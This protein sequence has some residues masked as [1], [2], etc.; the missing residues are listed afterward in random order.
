MN[1]DYNIKTMTLHELRSLVR[2]EE[3]RR[4]AAAL[5][6]AEEAARASGYNLKELLGQRQRPGRKTTATG[7]KAAKIFELMQAGHNADSACRALGYKNGGPAYNIVR[8]RG[9]NIVG[10]YLVKGDGL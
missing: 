6:A 8:N 5:D 2:T 9:H 1:A 3:R 7:T 10:G 4:Q